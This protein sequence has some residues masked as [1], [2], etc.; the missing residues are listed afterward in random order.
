MTA[1]CCVSVLARYCDDSVLWVCQTLR[2]LY[3]LY[4]YAFQTGS[5]QCRHSH[6]LRPKAVAKGRQ[7]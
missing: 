7:R 3:M 2:T 5:F 6:T 4:R 1:G